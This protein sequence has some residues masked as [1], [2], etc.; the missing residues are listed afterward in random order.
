MWVEQVG[1]G[2][3]RNDI[4]SVS[5][6]PPGAFGF[7]EDEDGTNGAERQVRDNDTRSQESN[8]PV[9]RV[10]SVSLGFSKRNHA[11]EV[12]MLGW[13]LNIERIGV[14][15]DYD[16]ACAMIARL[17]GEVAA[18]GLGGTNLHLVA[19]D[20]RVVKRSLAT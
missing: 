12:E 19:G 11:V 14:D 20:R 8:S 16:R 5:F 3:R 4:A 18:I 6:A 10:V 1:A 7:A 2:A 17:D 15:S 13:R 9:L